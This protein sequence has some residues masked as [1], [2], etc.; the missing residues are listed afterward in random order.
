LRSQEMILRDALSQRNLALSRDCA[1]LETALAGAAIPSLLEPYRAETLNFCRRYRTE[2]QMSLL[3]LGLG[4]DA[5]LEDILSKT[6]VATH[7]LRLLS[8]RLASPILR[9]GAADALC[10]KILNWTHQAHPQTNALPAAFSDGDVA[11]WPF[12]RVAPVYFFPCLEQGGLLYQPLHF[13]EFGHVVYV[14]H[15][16]EMDDLV[17]EIQKV[18][19]DALTPLS[20]HNDRHAA[21]LDARREL[22]VNRWFD[23]AQEVF[24][25]AVGL[26]IGG[27]AYLYAFSEYCNTLSRGDFYLPGEDLG[28]SPHPVPLLRI[29]LLVRRAREL[30]WR[31]A[32]DAVEAEWDTVAQVIK[33][34]EDYH[35]FFEDVMGDDIHRIIGDMLTV[36]DLRLCP[37]EDLDLKRLPVPGDTPVAVLNAAW[38][39]YRAKPDIYH[40]WE[41]ESI[42]AYL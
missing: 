5:L 25:D 6:R 10:L 12:L 2:A 34:T 42:L 41:R 27:P 40:N 24:C 32:A 17:K 22:V 1:A 29:R 11:V 4:N 26:T 23:W 35:G 30:G 36:A 39:Q 16:P 18:V 21:A 8:S 15:R 20:Q 3:L 31:E 7:Y 38:I 19:G 9:C 33:V 13:H 37:P 14:L 28:K